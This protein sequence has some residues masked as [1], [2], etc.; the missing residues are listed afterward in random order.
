MWLR[1]HLSLFPLMAFSVAHRRSL[2]RQWIASLR[3]LALPIVGRP[4]P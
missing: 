2:S 3:D 1:S 4:R